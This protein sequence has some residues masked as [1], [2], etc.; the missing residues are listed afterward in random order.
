MKWTDPNY[1][2]QSQSGT[3]YPTHIDNVLSVS[4]RRANWFNC[5]EQD[6]GSPAPDLSVRVDD[7][8]VW[9][10]NVTLTEVPAQTVSGFTTPTAGTQRIDR[11]VINT[12]TGVATRIAGTAVPTGSPSAV[13]PAITAGNMPC[14]Q[15]LL[16][17]SSTVITNSMITDERVFPAPQGGLVKLAS[18]TVSAAAT[19]DIVLSSYTGYKT[20]LLKLEDWRPATDGATLTVRTSTNAG[21][22]YDSGAGNYEHSGLT[23]S[24]TPTVTATG[25]ASAT[26]IDTLAPGD[27]ATTGGM[28]G[29]I[30]LHNFPSTTKHASITWEI[31]GVSSAAAAIY[32]SGKGR[33]AAA[34]DA[35][36]IRLL[37][38]AGNI[39]EGS[40]T[41]YGLT[42]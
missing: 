9:D 10:A 2:S 6:I 22:A 41:L 42:D 34:Q 24:N 8:F 18:G 21:G 14:A 17:A 39:T 35:D 29:N 38:S 31:G 13:A 5:Y 30:W 16:T 11:V 25:S 40:W 26:S 3:S 7:G 23:T 36:A 15:V 20:L 4:K 1:T 19:L 32:S 37:F 12:S 28:S 27:S 33:R